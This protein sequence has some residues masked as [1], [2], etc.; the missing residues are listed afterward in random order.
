MVYG[1]SCRPELFSCFPPQVE[2]EEWEE[3]GAD[4]S[5]SEHMAT[6]H[7]CA[8]QQEEE[9]GRCLRLSRYPR[10]RERLEGA[11]RAPRLATH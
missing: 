1:S 11:G 8:L 7:T 2:G 5:P 4:Q 6:N 3:G 10:R 9:A